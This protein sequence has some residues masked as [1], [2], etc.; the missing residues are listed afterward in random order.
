MEK[1]SQKDAVYAAITE[2]LGETPP[3]PCTLTDEQRKQV[4]QLTL[5]QFE[6]GIVSLTHTPVQG[7]KNYMPSLTNNWLRKDKR[8]NGGTTY[9]TKN[10]GS[11]TGA[12]D[13]E[14]KNLK[15]LLK[16]DLSDQDRK[17]VEAAIESRKAQLAKEKAKDIEIDVSKLPE[18]LKH[19][20]G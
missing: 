15:K 10:P 9:K 13:A 6:A 3:N 2:V 19:L 18:S 5:E 4:H 1:I 12:G 20:A 8:L 11:R 7:L 14:I 17:S 16:M